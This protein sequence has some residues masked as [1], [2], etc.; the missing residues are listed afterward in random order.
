MKCDIEIIEWRPGEL[1][2]AERFFRRLSGT[3]P[4]NPRYAE[5]IKSARELVDHK[6]TVKAVFR[7]IAIEA[8]NAD[9]V[10]LEDG[11]RLTGKMP[12]RA[13]EAADE[14]YA[15]VI[16]LNGFEDVKCSDMLM[17]YY[18]DTWGS[19]YTERGQNALAEL[20]DDRIEGTGM[21]RTHMWCPGQHTFDLINQ[22][23]LFSVLEPEAIGCR[24]TDSLMMVPVKSSSGI[25]GIVPEETKNMPRPCDYCQF[26]KKCHPEENGCSAL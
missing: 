15:F 12:V 3:D 8:R 5:N 21:K 13:L 17:N 9:S 16:S 6:T 26:R 2:G 10:I 19:S 24:L 22:K 11:W 14:L 18:T 23:T 7:R 25:M 4:D 20:I 1:K